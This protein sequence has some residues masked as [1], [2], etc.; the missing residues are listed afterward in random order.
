MFLLNGQQ[1]L[2]VVDFTGDVHLLVKPTILSQQYHTVQTIVGKYAEAS[3]E[4]VINNK[5]YLALACSG[6]SIVL[7]YNGR[8]FVDYQ[9]L[10]PHQSL[11][12]A[13]V[14]ISSVD[15][16]TQHHLLAFSSYSYRTS[17]DLPSNLYR[18]N[19]ST[20]RFDTYQSLPST[21][22]T[23]IRFFFADRE[24]Y[25]A[26]ACSMNRTRTAHRNA[27]SQIY[28]WRNSVFTLFQQLPVPSA[29]DIYPMVI[30]CHT[31]LI[32]STNSA[33]Y[34]YYKENHSFKEHSFS[35]PLNTLHHPQH[36]RIKS[37][38]FLAVVHV[39]NQTTT[40]IYQQ[41]FKLSTRLGTNNNYYR[42]MHT[43]SFFDYIIFCYGLTVHVENSR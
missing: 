11:S 8:E 35:L 31:F 4:F 42:L 22:A 34:V 27:F 3:T 7:K 28:V 12:V 18:W 24:L 39:A 26:I 14:S 43:H 41:V 5:H 38:H 32:I 37:E 40:N 6:S 17:Y 30:G 33:S 13:F 25:L 2:S 29:Q 1:I 21:G 19:N 15:L 9:T 23:N 20:L 16:V 10:L 36:F